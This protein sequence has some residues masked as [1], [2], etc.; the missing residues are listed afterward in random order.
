[1]L[2]TLTV[3]IAFVTLGFGLGHLPLLQ[4]DE[5]RNAEIAR[6][7]KESDAW[8][9]PTYNGVDYL[10]K[11]AFYFKVVALSMAAFGDNETAVRLPSALFAAGLLAMGFAFCRRVYGSSR[12]AWLAV[13]VV[14]TMPLYFGHARI[15]IFDMMLTF[16]VCGAVFAGFLAEE[17]EDRA[18]RN[19]YLLGAA[20]AG[21]ATLVK[22]PVGFAVPLLVLL[23]SNWVT[24]R[25][26]AWKRILSPLNLLAFFAVTLPWFVGLCLARP[27][28]FYY[29]LV[30]ETFNRFASAEHFH[31][32]KPF[33]YYVLL[34]AGTFFPWSLLLPEAI[35]AWWRRRWL[36]HR[37]DVLCAVW[38]VTVILFFSISKSK[39]PGYILSVSVACGILAARVV[40]AAW[41]NPAGRAGWLLRRATMAFAALC[42][43]ALAFVALLQFWA[44][45]A[46]RLL[47][48]PLTIFFS[49]SVLMGA[50]ALFR[51]S[52]QLGFFS[53]AIFFPLFLIFDTH[54]LDMALESRSGRATAD[55]LRMLPRDTELATLKFFPNGAPFYLG[56]TLTLITADGGE[57]SNYIPY[58][59]HH[60][61]PWPTNIVAV[62]ELD[63]W[64]DSRR[65]PVFLLA[66]SKDREWLQKIA[67]ARGASV[68]ALS[69]RYVGVALPAP[70]EN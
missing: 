64:L 65:T 63:H 12:V 26:D 53:L 66:R 24:G 1:L 44:G 43:V 51:R 22:G 9:V 69:P 28:F 8:L 58:R 55:L 3:V 4:P 29:G 15:V 13:L 57:L 35:V 41:A 60:R 49:A 37:A 67:T 56:R 14:A 27:D 17:T 46:V 34:V 61:A 33:Y 30:E 38:C 42:L 40:A 39:Q 5:G 23:V 20:S 52:A 18:R 68:E 50:A 32:D 70:G 48:W 6:E 45:E 16:F 59:L 25:R 31:R 36:R 7:M 10:D 11:P 21:L 62:V 2:A 47:V 19:W 54:V